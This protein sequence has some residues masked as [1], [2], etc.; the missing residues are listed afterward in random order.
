[1]RVRGGVPRTYYIGLEAAAP[2]VPGRPRPLKALTVVPFGMEEG[3][4]YQLVDRTYVLSVGKPMQFRFFQSNER[5]EDRA[6]SLLEEIDSTMEELSPVEAHLPSEVHESVPV[7]LESKVTETGILELWF[8]A[9]DGRR[10]KLEF[11]VRPRKGSR[12]T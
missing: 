1:V 9:R 7:T 2:A 5:R 6:G 12:P 3:T 10:W 8:V 4:G 11:N